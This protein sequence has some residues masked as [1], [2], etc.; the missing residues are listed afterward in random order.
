VADRDAARSIRSSARR[1]LASALLA[2]LL[3]GGCASQGWTLYAQNGQHTRV[4]VRF[5]SDAGATVRVLAADRQ[6]FV[7]VGDSMPPRATLEFLDATTCGRLAIVR[8]LPPQRALVTLTSDGL[9][10][11]G[12]DDPATHPKL[13]LPQSDS[14]G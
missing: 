12:F 11:V 13:L 7:F 8:E 1:S 14:C 9:V 4:L 10:E 3:F 6:G 2:A 5:W